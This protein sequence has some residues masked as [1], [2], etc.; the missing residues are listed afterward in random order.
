MDTVP[1]ATIINLLPKTVFLYPLDKSLSRDDHP[2]A[3]FEPMEGAWSRPRVKSDLRAILLDLGENT[4]EV[5]VEELIEPSLPAFIYGVF[6]IVDESTAMTAKLFN[7][8]RN[9]LLIPSDQFTATDLDSI[10]CRQ[11]RQIV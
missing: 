4:S 5:L 1:N 9:D 11:F 3:Q 2:I 7:R 6:Y 8:T 10:A